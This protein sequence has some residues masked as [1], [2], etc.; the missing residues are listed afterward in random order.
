MI[1]NIVAMLVILAGTCAGYYVGF[2]F[3]QRRPSSCCADIAEATAVLRQ[4]AEVVAQCRAA[5]PLI[6]SAI[7]Y[8][9]ACTKQKCGE[10]PAV[11]LFDCNE[12]VPVEFNQ[13]PPK[14]DT[15]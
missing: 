7:D 6:E 10:R 5:G 2:E 3:G 11:V 15:K 12:R 1:N 4:A 14:E 13:T 9:G 8:C